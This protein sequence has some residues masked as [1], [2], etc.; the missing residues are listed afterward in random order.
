MLDM[1]IHDAIEKGLLT[2]DSGN[3]LY[4]TTAEKF[5]AIEHKLV[6]L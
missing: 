3:D 2:Q 4:I 5:H 1:I 6:E